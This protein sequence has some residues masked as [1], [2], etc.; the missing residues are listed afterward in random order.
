MVFVLEFR[1][2]HCGVLSVKWIEVLMYLVGHGTMRAWLLV[3][4]VG[5]V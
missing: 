4:Y 2:T 3:G 5:I 1:D